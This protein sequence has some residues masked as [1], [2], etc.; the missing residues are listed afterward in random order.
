MA[1]AETLVEHPERGM[2]I[3]SGRRQLASIWPYLIQYRVV[4]EDVVLLTIRHGARRP[5]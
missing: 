1:T 5:L 4:G 2:R 3:G